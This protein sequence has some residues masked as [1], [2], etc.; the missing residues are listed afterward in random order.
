MRYLHV[1]GLTGIMAA[2][3]VRAQTAP[4]AAEQMLND[5]L[6]PKPSAV[7][8]SPTTRPT[9]PPALEPVGYVPGASSGHLLREGS[10]IIARRGHLK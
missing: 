4:S 6:R 7:D 8:S 10:D 5:M 3:A 2:S 9:S 1:I